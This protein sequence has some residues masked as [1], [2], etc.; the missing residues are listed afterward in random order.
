[1]NYKLIGYAIDFASFLLEKLKDAEKMKSVI[2]FGSVARG[3]NEK[4]SDID[5]FIECNEKLGNKINDLKEKFYESIKVKKYWELLDV[6]NEINLHIGKLEGW[7]DLKRSIIANG[8]ILYGKYLEKIEGKQSYLFIVSPG[9]NRNKNMSIWRELYGYKQKVG[10]K[11]YIKEG[12]VKEYG[13]KK[14]ALGVF[15]I[16]VEHAQ[17]IN[18]FL[19]KKKFKFQIIPFWTD[20]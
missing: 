1:M 7:G 11:S 17:K 10:K 3:D 20:K 13:G 6:K 14:L 4:N 8:I 15:I 12:L 5:L 18:L 9:K 2:L 16:P 19:R